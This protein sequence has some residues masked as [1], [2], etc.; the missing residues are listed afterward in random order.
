MFAGTGVAPVRG[1]EDRYALETAVLGT[2]DYLAREDMRG[3]APP[4]K[5]LR[6]P[7]LAQY[8]SVVVARPK[9]FAKLVG[10]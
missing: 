9:I 7:D 6:K 1:E 10:L 5:W 3:C 4:A 2:A 8:D